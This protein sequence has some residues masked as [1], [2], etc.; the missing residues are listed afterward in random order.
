MSYAKLKLKYDEDVV[1]S[2]DNKKLVIYSIMIFNNYNKPS[3]FRKIDS[4]LFKFDNKPRKLGIM[5]I[6]SKKYINDYESIVSAVKKVE[7]LYEKTN[8]DNEVISL[9]DKENS[10]DILYIYDE[11]KK[12]CKI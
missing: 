10:K 6:K 8:K 7:K 12:F 4:V 1:I 2:G 9:Y 3:F 11:L 5:Q